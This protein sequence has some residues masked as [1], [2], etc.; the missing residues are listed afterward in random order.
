MNHTQIVSAFAHA[1]TFAPALDP[2]EDVVFTFARCSFSSK[3]L[4]HRLDFDA[5]QP[6]AKRM[7]M[8]PPSRPARIPHSS[9]KRLLPLRRPRRRR[10]P[11]AVSSP[12]P[13][14]DM[15]LAVS[16]PAS[17]VDTMPLTVSSPGPVVDM[18]LAVSSPGLVFITILE[19]VVNL[20]P[21]LDEDQQKALAS[22]NERCDRARSDLSMHAPRIVITI[23]ELI[24]DLNPPATEEG[25]KELAA[26]NSRCRDGHLSPHAPNRSNNTGAVSSTA[27]APSVASVPAI[28]VVKSPSSRSAP[29]SD[30]AKG[31]QRAVDPMAASGT[32][33]DIGTGSS[34]LT[35]SDIT[36]AGSRGRDKNKDRTV[37]NSAG[38]SSGGRVKTTRKRQN[39]SL[40]KSLFSRR[41]S[42]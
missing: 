29:M 21:K 32:A 23:T 15:P 9:I 4:A 2:M 35:L 31:K 3:P 13:V 37:D 16:S 1:H 24:V 20:N 33:F 26:W 7:K 40:I 34:S 14:V 42:A 12:S 36:N 39:G 11:L 19:L 38:K 5:E 8:G 18:P 28:P 6:P 10:I 22:W 30:K 17:V 27:V 25:K 41:M